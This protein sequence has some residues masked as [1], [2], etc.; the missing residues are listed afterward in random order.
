M[1]SPLQLRNLRNHKARAPFWQHVRNHWCSQ[2][3][4]SNLAGSKKRRKKNGDSA[5]LLIDWFVLGK[6]PI[7]T[8]SFCTLKTANGVRV[9]Q[10][11]Q[12]LQG[13]DQAIP[14]QTGNSFLLSENL[15]R[16][17]T[18]NLSYPKTYPLKIAQT[19]PKT[20]HWMPS[21]LHMLWKWRSSFTIWKSS[22]F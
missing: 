22:Q 11:F 12:I 13:K 8:H 21:A 7:R 14:L 6:I 4:P 1:N 20:A 2:F 10:H 16:T 15:S 17:Y 3:Q 5:P 19:Y 18:L 9:N